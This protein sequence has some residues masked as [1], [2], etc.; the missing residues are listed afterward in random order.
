MIRSEKEIGY[1]RRVMT[2]ARSGYPKATLRETIRWLDRINEHDRP[3]R[4]DLFLRQYGDLRAREAAS[5]V[6]RGLATDR[7]ISIVSAFGNG[8][9]AAR[10][11]WRQAQRGKRH[12][13]ALLPK[14]NGRKTSQ[15]DTSFDP[16]WN[17]GPAVSSC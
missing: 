3:A 8:L 6:T 15:N 1:F 13:S 5:R 16:S 14:M 2:S 9:A 4:L 10:T 7:E 17:D 12:A 11:R